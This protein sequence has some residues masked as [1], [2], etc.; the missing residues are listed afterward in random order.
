[1]GAFARDRVADAF[2]QIDVL[3]VPS[4][5]LENSPLVIH[6]AFMAG[7][8]VVAARIGGIAGL[9]DH[10]VNGILYDPAAAGDLCAALRR[11]LDDPA[12]VR[13]LACAAPAVK[14]IAQDAI[15]WESLYDE[16]ARPA[17][18]ARRG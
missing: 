8:A 14:P 4:L 17:A 3:V 7:V 1:M 16:V 13:R 12:E 10:G 15:A 18:A 9:V 5:W 6:E 2:G 11:L